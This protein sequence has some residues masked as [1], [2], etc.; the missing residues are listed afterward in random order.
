MPAMMRVLIIV[1]GLF[2]DVDHAVIAAV[3]LVVSSAAYLGY[4]VAGTQFTANDA[5]FVVLARTALG[6]VFGI[7]INFRS[8]DNVVV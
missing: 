4:G 5:L 8:A 6:V 7:S 1:V 3:V 2:A